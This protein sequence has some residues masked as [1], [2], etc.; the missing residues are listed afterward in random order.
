MLVLTEGVILYHEEP[1]VASLADDLRS[2]AHVDGWIV[3]YVSKE[4]LAYRERA[5]VN[6]LHVPGGGHPTPSPR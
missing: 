6:R 1:Q 3:D 4:S 2:L 5:G